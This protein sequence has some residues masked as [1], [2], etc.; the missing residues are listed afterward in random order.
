M[1][2]YIYLGDETIQIL[3][4]CTLEEERENIQNYLIDINF[5]YKVFMILR[6]KEIMTTLINSK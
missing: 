3:D 1:E 5:F 6:K 4:A 2:K